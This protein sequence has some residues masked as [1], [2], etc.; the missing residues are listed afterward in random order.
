MNK[1]ARVFKP[2]AATPAEED[3]KVAADVKDSSTAGAKAVTLSTKGKAFVPQKAGL[4]DTGRVVVPKGLSQTVDPT[5]KPVQTQNKAAPEPEKKADTK[6]LDIQQDEASAETATASPEKSDVKAPST[7]QIDLASTNTAKEEFSS[8]DMKVLKTLLDSKRS[9]A[10]MDLSA[11]KALKNISVCQC[12]NEDVPIYINTEIMTRDSKIKAYQHSKDKKYGG[13]KNKNN[14]NGNNSSN[15]FQKGGGQYSKPSHHQ[16]NHHHKKDFNKINRNPISKDTLRMREEADKW[17]DAIK[18]ADTEDSEKKAKAILNKITP[19]SYK[20]MRDQ[21]KDVVIN[22]PTDEDRTKIIKLFFKK[23][24]L[25][26]KYCSLYVNLIKYIGFK[27]VEIKEGETPREADTPVE[28]NTPVSGVARRKMAS[29]SKFKKELVEHCKMCLGEFTQKLDLS[30]IPE[31]DQED[32]TYRY[33]KRLFGNLKFIGELIKKKL[34]PNSVGY[35]VPSILLGMKDDSSYNEFTIEGA[36]TFITRVGEHIDC[37]EKIENA[38]E[39]NETDKKIKLFKARQEKFDEIINRLS[40]FH[41]DESIEKRIQILITNVFELREN[42]WVQNIKDDGPKTMKQIKKEHYQELRGEEVKPSKPKRSSI[43]KT[44]N[45]KGKRSLGTSKYFIGHFGEL[46]MSKMDSRISQVSGFNEA[47]DNEEEEKKAPKEY[48]PRQQEHIDHEA[49]K[50]KFIGNFTEWL[51]NGELNLELFKKKEN[52]IGG[53]K[54]I[55]F[56]LEKLYDK[57]EEEVKKFNEYFLAI[58]QN[59]VFLKKDVEMGVTEFFR[60]IPNIE[61]DYP[62]LSELFSEFIY[63]VFISE[64]IADF[65]RV[66]IE[67]V[68]DEEPL[69]EDEEPM[70]FIDIYFKILGALFTKINDRL[71]DEKVDHYYS[72]FKVENTVKLLRPHVMGEDVFDEIK[73]EFNTPDKIINF[74][75]VETS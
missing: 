49:I 9:G 39:N 30:E 31:G 68:G 75:N 73:E 25:E 19:D 60:T 4:K 3:K 27:E 72:H 45:N 22:C 36:C 42:Q 8:I 59:K 33:K 1:A 74:L 26:D 70:Y 5:Q 56:L 23:S 67:L 43:K 38:K 48:S 16:K 10:K 46:A 34:I 18:T 53:H 24:T 55:S 17:K 63:F 64:N 54:I 58:Y 69:K 6:E 12:K 21:I 41:T 52:K 44:S 62:H 47:S 71:G 51:A 32:Y 65:S 11:F 61:S 15:K 13:Y 29:E 2:K 35:L 57:T 7:I 50:D 14:Y 28:E 66:E 37:R 20:K 40:V